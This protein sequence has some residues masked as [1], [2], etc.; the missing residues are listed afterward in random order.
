MPLNKLKELFST[1]ISEAISPKPQTQDI[2]PNLPKN[3]DDKRDGETYQNW[4]TRICASTGGSSYTLDSFLHK[5]YQH[6]RHEQADN[7]NLQDQLLKQ[8]QFQINSKNGEVENLNTQIN[9]CNEAII[10]KNK[11]ISELKDEINEIK[12]KKEEVNKDQKLKMTIGLIILIPLTLYLFLF[13]SSTFQSAFFSN[14]TDITTVT[15]AMFNPHALTI[16]Y[17][18]GIFELLFVLCAPIIFLALGFTLHFFSEQKGFGKWIKMG[19]ILIVTLFFDCILAYKIGEM[20]H[21]YG[22]IIGMVLP[23]EIYTIKLAI[24]DINTWAVI[25]CGFIVYIIWGIVFDMTISAYH[26]LDLCKTRTAAITG[27]I[28]SFEKQINTYNETITSLK[29]QIPQLNSEIQNLQLDLHNKNYYDIGAI[30]LEMSNFFTG[31]MVTLA[32]ILHA[33]PSEQE[34]AKETFNETINTLAK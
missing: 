30:K 5:V 29:T 14:I 8:I 27:Q 12:A 13:Y 28:N 26:N 6:I 15:S 2:S 3:S 32:G 18:T 11:K 17:K 21:E 19:S 23:G 22:K 20:I 31:W 7:Q 16:A 25:F 34:K 4:G 10:T 24:Q 1:K 9:S 33:S